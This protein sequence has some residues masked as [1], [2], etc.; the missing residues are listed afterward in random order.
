MN[1]I[2]FVVANIHLYL[3]IALDL[4]VLECLINL[5][6]GFYNNYSELFTTVDIYYLVLSKLFHLGWVVDL[7]VFILS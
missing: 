1:I 5:L 6:L 4:E 2:P 3:F 7:F